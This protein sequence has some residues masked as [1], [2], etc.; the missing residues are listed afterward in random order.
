MK[1]DLRCLRSS[2]I[3]GHFYEILMKLRIMAVSDALA[4]KLRP[5]LLS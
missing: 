1:R 3:I 5:V 4:S 2:S